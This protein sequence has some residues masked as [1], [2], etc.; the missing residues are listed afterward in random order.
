MGSCLLEEITQGA[1]GGVTQIMNKTF[2]RIDSACNT[3]S[4]NGICISITMKSVLKALC[5]EAEPLKANAIMRIMRTNG[6]EHST[7][8]MDLVMN[9]LVNM[10]MVSEIIT[11]EL[12]YQTVAPRVVIEKLYIIEPLTAM[13]VHA[14]KKGL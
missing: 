10:G 14:W 1:P 13:H 5:T 11:R 4:L 6:Y 8:D 12:H 3:G 9:R 2:E 7:L